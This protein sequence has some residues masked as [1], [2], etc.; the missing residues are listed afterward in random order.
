M[1]LQTPLKFKSQHGKLYFYLL[2]IHTVAL[3]PCGT[4][5][6][7]DTIG[8]T[9]ALFFFFLSP[10]LPSSS[11][12]TSSLFTVGVLV[13]SQY[14]VIGASINRTDKVKVSNLR[15][16]PIL[17]QCKDQ[18][19]LTCAIKID[20]WLKIYFHIVPLHDFFHQFFPYFCSTLIVL[21]VINWY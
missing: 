3:F 13:K 1:C 14:V 19:R 12:S 6:N 16:I 18:G 21:L 8:T 15:G 10:F 7:L 4:E 2:Q 5:M 11:T 17:K 20:F 9:L